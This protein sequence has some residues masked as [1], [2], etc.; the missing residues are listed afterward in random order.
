LLLNVARAASESAA[1][2]K[3]KPTSFSGPLVAASPFC[4][5]SKLVFSSAFDATGGGFGAAGFAASAEGF[6][7]D[8]F[9]G[10]GFAGLPH[11]TKKVIVSNFNPLC[12]IRFCSPIETTFPAPS[13]TDLM[14]NSEVLQRT[15]QPFQYSKQNYINY[16][17]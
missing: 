14:A 9:G 11:D 15:C 17:I 5:A 12:K 4:K 7:A 3:L 1:L 10:G 16:R 13:W 6:S 2:S 8:H